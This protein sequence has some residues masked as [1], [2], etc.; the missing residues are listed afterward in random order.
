MHGGSYSDV[1]AE[2]RRL[3]GK[4]PGGASRKG[5][6]VNLRT[7]GKADV[8]ENANSGGKKSSNSKLK[9]GVKT[10]LAKGQIP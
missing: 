7:W 10:E 8:Y 3:G 6:V 2:K 9:R 1:R 4:Q 5:V